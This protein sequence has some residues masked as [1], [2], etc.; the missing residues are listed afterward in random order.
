MEQFAELQKEATDAKCKVS[1]S[2][3][4]ME[5]VYTVLAL[6]GLAFLVSISYIGMEQQHL[7]VDF[8]IAHTYR[9]VKSIFLEKPKINI[10]FI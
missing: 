9:F 3:I 10:I 6:F 1:I 7:V 2:Y 8:I 5:L 4:G